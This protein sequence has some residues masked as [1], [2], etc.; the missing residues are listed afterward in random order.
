MKDPLPRNIEAKAQSNSQGTQVSS[1]PHSKK[2]RGS[3]A[4]PGKVQARAQNR[5]QNKAQKNPSETKKPKK[6]S[7]QI[8]ED[9]GFLDSLKSEW[10]LFWENIVGD[11]DETAAKDAKKAAVSEESQK[12]PFS[13]GKLERLSLEQIKAITKVLSQ[14]RAQLNQKLEKINREL[15]ENMAKAQSLAL[16][17]GDFEEAQSKT[18]EL[19]ELGQQVAADLGKIDEQLKLARRR[20]DVL[21]KAIKK[22]D[23]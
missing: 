9:L 19:N 18:S 17:G 16:V 12:D 8:T 4:D 5:A 22:L 6:S 14:D 3:E 13:T 20:E 1:G 7:P 10:N 15:E 2:A 23:L 21:K 11:D